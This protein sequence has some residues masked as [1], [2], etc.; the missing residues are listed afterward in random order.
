MWLS[1]AQQRKCLNSTE[2]SMSVFSDTRNVVSSVNLNNIFI[3]DK[4]FK[5]LAITMYKVG[6]RPEPWTTPM[7]IGLKEE[8]NDACFT[9]WVL[10]LRKEIIHCKTDVLRVI[11][12]MSLCLI[13]QAGPVVCRMTVNEIIKAEITRKQVTN[14]VNGT[15]I[16]RSVRQCLHATRTL[17]RMN[18]R[19]KACV[20]YW[21]CTLHST[22]LCKKRSRKKF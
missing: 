1:L 6:P 17:G 18:G 7:L 20:Q 9:C 4:G 3:T 5:S 11:V 15:K 8:K 13:L 2:M 22:D 19:P 21:R 10:P 16:K 14:H 12:N